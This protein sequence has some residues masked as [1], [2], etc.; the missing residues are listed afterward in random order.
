MSGQFAR[1]RKSTRWWYDTGLLKSHSWSSP[2]FN[3]PYFIYNINQDQ[4]SI[5]FDSPVDVQLAFIKFFMEIKDSILS[6]EDTTFLWVLWE[7]ALF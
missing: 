7:Y 3:I 4:P 1:Q 6:L 2:F 5:V